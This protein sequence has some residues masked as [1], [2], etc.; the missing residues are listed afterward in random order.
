MSPDIVLHEYTDREF[1]GAIALIGFPSVGL[2]SSIAASYVVKN[3]KLERV[4]SMVSP[5]FPPYTLIYD[6]LPSPPV[7]IYAGKRMCD[8]N[9]EQCE[10]LVV[11][12]AEFMPKPDLIKPVVDKILEWCRSKGIETI[13]TLEGMNTGVDPKEANTLC[14]ASGDKCSSIVED[15]GLEEMNEGMVSGISGVLLYEADRLGDEVMCLLGPAKANYP[16]A[17]GAARLL[18]K[19][20]D[21][22]PELKLDAEPFYREAEQ[23]EQQMKGAMEGI[24]QQPKPLSEGSSIL[25]G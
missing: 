20:G 17:R 11:I 7:R 15:Y 1:P 9:G 22:L 4:A 24:K 14:I 18:E 3:L 21:M 6:G 5:E 25:Y 16:D 8:Q 23:I 13:I 2:V 19:V 12:T 10:Q